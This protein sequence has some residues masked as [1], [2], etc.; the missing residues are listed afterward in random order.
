MNTLLCSW[1]TGF[2]SMESVD[3]TGVFERFMEYP[4]ELR[5]CCLHS[6]D[7]SE[8]FPWTGEVICDR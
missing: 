6:L 2:D 3:K 5:Q 1:Y 8:I 7:L 4:D